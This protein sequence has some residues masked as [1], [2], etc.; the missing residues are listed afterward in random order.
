MA[1]TG[2][3][4]I[5][6]G[7]FVTSDISGL[8]MAAEWH[9][10]L[11]AEVT[12][13]ATKDGPVDRVADPVDTVAAELRWTNA[14]S[15]YQTV[16]VIVSRPSRSVVTS[17]P[18]MVALVDGVSAAISMTT[19]NAPI[20]SV[21]RGP[22]GGVRLKTTRSTV[23]TP[24]FGRVFADILGGTS[25]HVYNVGPGLSIHFRYRCA[26][27]TPGDWRP[28]SNGVTEAYARFVNLKMYAYPFVTG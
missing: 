22:G 11:V 13:T 4:R 20:P 24:A 17:N 12:E 6:T 27:T 18:N 21:T 28:P 7:D 2:S 15:T 19:P 14:T 3:V 10:R 23:S 25:E 8:R 9:P 16:S 26:I 1:R 5:C